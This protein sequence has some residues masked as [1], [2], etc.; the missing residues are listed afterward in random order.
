MGRRPRGRPA[1]R[2]ILIAGVRTVV[3]V[4]VVVGCYLLVM[5]PPD[6]LVS[7][8]AVLSH[9]LIQVHSLLLGTMAYPDHYEFPLDA[10]ELRRSAGPDDWR[11]KAL[12]KGASQEG[13]HALDAF[14]TLCR[15]RRLDADAFSGRQHKYLV[16]RFS[17]QAGLANRIL[18]L[19]SAFVVALLTNRTFL[20][21]LSYK[22][23]Q[24]QLKA[25][26]ADP[27]FYWDLTTEA[28]LSGLSLSDLRQKLFH[29]DVPSWKF[30]Q[31]YTRELDMIHCSP[32]L[33]REIKKHSFIVI[34]SHQYFLPALLHNPHYSALLKD[35][36]GDDIFGV[37]S[38]FLFRPVASIKAEVKRF[39]DEHL[40]QYR[41]LG[42]QVRTSWVPNS[43]LQALAGLATSCVKNWCTENYNNGRPVRF[44]VATD[45]LDI[46][47]E[48]EQA[49]E[50]ADGGSSYEDG[51]LLSYHPSVQTRETTRGIQ[52]ALIDILLLSQCDDLITSSFSTFGYLASGFASKRPLILTPGPVAGKSVWHYQGLQYSAQYA[53]R[54]LCARLPTS[55]PCYHAWDTVAHTSCSRGAETAAKEAFAD[56]FC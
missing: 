51:R 44:F 52:E 33:I 18:S 53:S 4:V 32:D 10:E 21:D 36:F 38:S 31:H 1:C 15:R 42:I 29:K 5:G 35:W 19:T 6:L 23:S 7:T 16:V 12:A 48:L 2:P 55:Q 40:T 54:T 13:I 45:S 49:L 56:R 27:D 47:N 24:F 39:Y 41:T 34:G 30:Y 20:V 46:R 8:H 43:E 14:S 17:E 25:L 28:Q 3:A 9:H 26:F 22:A 50:D 11:T 37:L